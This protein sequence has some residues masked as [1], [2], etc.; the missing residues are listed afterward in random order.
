MAPS[1]GNLKLKDVQAAK[2]ALLER[3]QAR[4]A[5][6]DSAK[7]PN[8]AYAGIVGCLRNGAT[9]LLVIVLAASLCTLQMVRNQSYEKAIKSVQSGNFTRATGVVER[10]TGVNSYEASQ[11]ISNLQQV[12][13]EK[14]SLEVMLRELQQQLNNSQRENVKQAEYM[15]MMERE[16][17]GLL[18]NMTNLQATSSDKD[19]REKAL[20]LMNKY[21][22][23]VDSKKK[24]RDAFNQKLQEMGVSVSAGKLIKDQRS[25]GVGVGLATS[26]TT[27]SSN[28]K[29][30]RGDG[31]SGKSEASGKTASVVVTRAKSARSDEGAVRRRSS[32]TKE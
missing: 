22:A 16:K 19:S 2:A 31:P 9:W 11:I 30:L 13:I 32:P 3:V 23:K 17:D 28:T 21:K 5:S 14:S 6:G 15:E 18:K 10:E 29:R 7:P 25:R 1:L 4:T 24:E 20:V 26:V 27:K 8:E 12:N